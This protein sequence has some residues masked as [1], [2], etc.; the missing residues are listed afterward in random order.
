MQ[1][2]LVDGSSGL[3]GDMWV[4]ALLELGFELEVLRT[5]VGEL[6]LGGVRLEADS[7]LRAGLR[8]IWFRVFVDP[9]GPR[10][11]RHLSDILAILE[12]SSAA[13]PVVER[14]SAV[15]TA[16]AEA[17]A[18]VHGI[19]IEAVHFHEVGADDTIV[20]VFGACLAVHSLG[21]ERLVATPIETGC[22][23]VRCEHG[24]LPVPAPATERLLRGLPVTSSG[25]AGERTTPTGAALARVLVDA[26][27]EP[28]AWVPQ[29]SGYGAGTRD[30][31]GQPNLCR[32]TLGEARSEGERTVLYELA[33]NL[34]Q[35]TGETLSYLID[36]VLERGAHDAFAVPIVMKKGR[37]AYLFSAIVAPS[38]RERV[39][40]F[41]IEESG[42]LGL[43]MH[44][45]ERD[46]IERWQE[47]SE[48][49]FGAVTFK[50]ARLPSGVV[51]RRPEDDELL[52]LVREQGLGR[53]ALLARLLA[54]KST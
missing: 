43:R 22:G 11:H 37:P 33:V 12:R 6:K 48:T 10:P 36:G 53:R 5:A 28:L 29:R 27:D 41:V 24:V 30:D 35:A 9:S 2:A 44:R 8:G 17:E 45:V 18:E 1:I 21:I 25:L 52:R 50:C 54:Q 38:E 51:Q 26:F 31:A 46:V 19:G 7:V 49:E 16:I 40:A 32:I 15:F 47:R 13:A 3:A 4:G 20:D 39:A 23:T 42:S 34:D 14:A